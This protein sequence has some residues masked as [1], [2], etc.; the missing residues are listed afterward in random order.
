MTK[1]E[2]QNL[3]KQKSQQTVDFISCLKHTIGEFNGTYFDLIDWQ[4]KIIRDV[5]GTLKEDGTRQYKTVYVEIPKKQGKS[6]LLAAIALKQLCADDEWA[7]E[8]YGCAADKGQAGIIFNVAKA[9]IEQ[10]PEL[11][12]KCKIIDSI[13]RI[14]YLPTN[15]FYQVLSSEAFTKHGLNVSTCLFDEVHAQPNRALYDVMTFGSGDAR[16]QPMFWFITTAGDDPDR[17]SIGWELHEKAENIL[18][19]NKVDPS[20]Y[21]VIF[22]IDEENHRV[23]HGWGYKTFDEINWKDHDIWRLVNPSIDKTVKFSKLEE[24]LTNVEGNSADEKLFKQLRLNIWVKYKATKW[25]AY[26]VWEKNTGIVDR[27]RLRSRIAYGG[28][29]VASKMDLTAFVLIFPPTESDPKYSVLPT[30]WIP[31]DNVEEYVKKYNLAYRKW[32]EMGLLKTTPGNRIDYEFICKEICEQAS[33][34]DIQK[35]GFDPWA[36]DSIHTNLV[37]GGFQEDQLIEIPQ[38]FANLSTPMQELEAFLKGSHFNHG[39]NPIMNWM[40]GNLEV[41]TNANGDIRPT[42]SKKQGNSKNKTGT[43]HYKIDGITAL[44]DALAVILRIQSEK[45]VYD[46]RPEGEK[47]FVV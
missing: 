14:V 19:G 13:K 42:K 47:V 15:S 39:N 21:P 45:S 25:L 23:W 29:D 3:S 2:L 41:I 8:V 20:F 26:D 18:L 1:K 27:Q 4:D 6:E 32:I 9:M 31:E 7:A 16:L 17:M 35:I 11:A 10:E 28:L 43:T 22:G 44:I 30:F 36:V 37:N 38:R 34:F 46:Q 12:S 33:E 40:F 5:Y 24:A